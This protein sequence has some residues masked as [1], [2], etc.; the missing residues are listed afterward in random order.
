MK[1]ITRIFLFACAAALCML[2]TA[3]GGA[4]KAELAPYLSVTYSGC[5]GNGTASVKFDFS[6]FEYDIMS[7][8]KGKGKLEKLAKLTAVERTITYSA[9]VS[10]GLRNGD[11]ITVKISYNEAK[12]KEYG[13]SFTALDKKFTVEG[14]EEPIMIDPF[15]ENILKLSVSGTAPFAWLEIGYTGD[16]DAPEAHI[17][18]EADKEFEL[19]N[20]D[21]VT[22]TASISENYI[23]KGYQLTRNEMNLT[24]E[25]LESYI[26]D[27]SALRKEDVTAIQG[28]VTE[29]FNRKVEQEWLDLQVEGDT[30]SVSKSNIGSLG[31]LRFADSGYAVVQNGWSE[32]AVLVIPFTVD[33]HDAVFNWWGIEYHEEPLVKNF[34]D[35]NGYFVVTDLKL[36]ADGRLIREGNFH[37]EVSILYENEHQMRDS[38]TEKFGSEGVYQGS[39]AN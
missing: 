23:R 7:R 29:F 25:G 30:K 14:L 10:E 24:V 4:T 1:K 15:D 17:R 11:I 12:A 26:T 34:Y 38:V 22:V 6:D 13:Y 18:Y 32:T 39:F 8:W 28:K 36:D 33:I 16:R 37:M 27:V 2:F 35:L 9:D 5:N 20:G 19:K 3:C 21:T 31:R